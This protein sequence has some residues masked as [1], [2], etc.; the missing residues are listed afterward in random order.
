[1]RGEVQNDIIEA[2]LGSGLNDMSSMVYR[3][4]T[5]TMASAS[6][7]RSAISVDIEEPV[8]EGPIFD[9]LNIMGPRVDQ[10]DDILI[11]EMVDRGAQKGDEIVNNQ[12]DFVQSLENE[13]VSEGSKRRNEFSKNFLGGRDIQKSRKE[14]LRG[15]ELDVGSFRLYSP[16][17]SEF[18]FAMTQSK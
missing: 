17:S 12:I 9:D 15:V 2:D 1:M 3:A 16:T 18:D 4:S 5:A 8:Y 10:Q 6:V 7:N 14:K 11:E 13:R